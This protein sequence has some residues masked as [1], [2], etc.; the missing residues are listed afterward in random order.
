MLI[1]ETYPSGDHYDQLLQS[2]ID[3]KLSEITE[4]DI[5]LFKQNCIDLLKNKP[6]FTIVPNQL[7]HTKSFDC[8]GSLSEYF[9]GGANE[10]VSYISNRLIKECA[11]FSLMNDGI[12]MPVH[13]RKNW[14][15]QININHSLG[16]TLF[17]ISLDLLPYEAF[18]IVKLQ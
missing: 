3:K 6:R 12:L 11:I 1:S 10:V 7:D 16:N 8:N 17:D 18:S 15:V 9:A 4:A 13:P 14:S 5:Y 2:L